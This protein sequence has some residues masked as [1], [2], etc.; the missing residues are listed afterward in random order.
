MLNIIIIFI[1]ALFVGNGGSEIS[2]S[3]SASPTRFNYAIL[4]EDCKPTPVD[5]DGQDTYT[6]I[7]FSENASESDEKKDHSC[8]FDGKNQ[9]TITVVYDI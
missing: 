6:E 2:A 1:L 8:R 9:L 5:S 4:H 7:N 3:A